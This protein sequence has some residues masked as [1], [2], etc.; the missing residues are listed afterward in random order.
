[1]FMFYTVSPGRITKMLIDQDGPEWR[2]KLPEIPVVPLS[3]Q[4]QHRQ[5]PVS[6]EVAQARAARA[7]QEE[8]E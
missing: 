8:G 4:E 5:K 3:V 7:A 1:M 6:I 2:E